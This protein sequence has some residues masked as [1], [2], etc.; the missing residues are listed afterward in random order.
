MSSCFPARV[1]LQFCFIGYGA[2]LGLLMNSNLPY[3]QCQWSV[4]DQMLNQLPWK[5]ISG[6]HSEDFVSQINGINGYIRIW[7]VRQSSDICTRIRAQNSNTNCTINWPKFRKLTLL[8]QTCGNG[9][10]YIEYPCTKIPYCQ[11][12]TVWSNT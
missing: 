11:Q 5:F 4:R 7:Q 6:P 9:Y 1:S 10:Y 8:Y 3:R 12:M 2:I